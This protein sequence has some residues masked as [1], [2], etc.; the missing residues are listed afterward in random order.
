MQLTY[1]KGSKKQDA[2]TFADDHTATQG[3][4]KNHISS[5]PIHGSFHRVIYFIKVQ[6]GTFLRLS[7]V[8]R[9]QNCKTS[10]R[11][12]ATDTPCR[13]NPLNVSPKIK[14]SSLPNP[15]KPAPCSFP[16]ESSVRSP[17]HWPRPETW[18]NLELLLLSQPP[19]TTTTRAQSLSPLLP[20][21]LPYFRTAVSS[22]DWSP[23]LHSPL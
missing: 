15:G 20:N 19:N 5:L 1:S 6:V 9:Y 14:L 21:P 3:P 7:P 12:E 16:T 18:E 11:K 23:C 22:P 10:E 17:S 2:L 8:S 13:P 4:S